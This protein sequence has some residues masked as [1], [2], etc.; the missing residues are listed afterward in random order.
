VE[1]ETQLPPLPLLDALRTIES[2]M[3]SKKP[4]PKGPRIIDMD[5][6]LYS[7]EVVDTA[8]LQVP[9]PRMMQRRFVLVPLAEIAPHFRHPLWGGTVE[10]LLTQALDRSQV[11]RYDEEN[12]S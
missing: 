9:H 12:D 6:L 4:F 11:I 5:I 7:D 1:G 2:R 3:H 8:E 10:D